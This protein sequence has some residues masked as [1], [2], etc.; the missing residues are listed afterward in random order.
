MP[1]I[2]KKNS[3]ALKTIATEICHVKELVTVLW[4]REVCDQ[5]FG[6]SIHYL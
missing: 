6:K 4:L 2:E 1:Y 5:S 3:Y